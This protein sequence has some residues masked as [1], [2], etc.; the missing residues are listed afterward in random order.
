MARLTD[1]QAADLGSYQVV[2]SDSAGEVTSVVAT[3]AFLQPPQIVSTSPALGAIWITNN[4]PNTV[5]Q[6]PLT[7]AATDGDPVN[8][9]LSYQWSLDGTN[10]PGANSAVYP[11]SVYDYWPYDA[12]LEGDY[13]VT[14][15]NAAGSTNVG[16][17]NI[18]VLLQGMV[19]AWGDDA[20]GQCD[21][22]VT[23]TNAM[24]LAAGAY[25][26]AA[27]RDDGT[28][29]QW[30]DY[31]PDDFQSQN[32]PAPVGSPPTNS[33]IVAVAA[34]IAHDLALKA[35]GTVIQWGLAGASGLNN[36][37]TN[38]TGVKAVGV[39]CERS[40]ALLTN[41]TIVDWGLFVPILGLDQRVPADLTNVTA[42]SCGAYHYLA[43]R[44]NGTVASWG[45]N[46]L[47]GETNVPAGLSNVVAVAGGGRH[48]LAL[49]AD[50]TVVAWGDDTYGQCDVPMGL[51][52][53]MAIAA[54]YFHSVALKNDGTV[55]SWG[56]NSDGQTNTPSTL[57]QIKLIA[58]GG[59]HTL[60]SMFSPLVQYPMDVTKDLLLI[61]NSNSADSSN[62]CAHYLAHRPMVAD[63]NVLGVACDV[64]EFF[65]SSNNCDAQ[66]VAPVLNWLANNPTKHPEY[67]VLFYDIPTR[68]S[69]SYPYTAYG[70]VSYHLRQSYPGWPPFVNNINAGSAADCESYVDKLA[71]IGTNYSPGKLIISAS[72]GEYG[73]TNF[74]IDDIR[75]GG[76]SPQ[77]EDYSSFG[78][79]VAA[80]TN[81]LLSAGLSPS[82][83]LFYDG[84]VISNNLASAPPHATGITNI[85]GYV[86][87]GVH[88]AL[89]GGYPTN[90]T[91]VWNGNS[92]W[93]IIATIESFNGIRGGY[94]QG[95]FTEWY[96]TDAFGGTNYSNTPVGA[97][98]N[99]EEPGGVANYSLYFGLW[100]AGKN[101]GI[102][103]WNA[104]HSNYFQAIGDPLV[105]K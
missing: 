86:S 73:N 39:G 55:V 96:S 46:T 26:S 56:D 60:A 68:L 5:Y 13:A 62:V 54:G 45:Y 76:P 97:M 57:S 94:G 88:G 14:V 83:I 104:D 102:C 52:N 92:G 81:S 84:L 98:S 23:L 30:G 66:L 32:P 19:A 38:L 16:T 85:A 58:A 59:Y 41:G 65:A 49:K 15:S 53:V 50:G 87:W 79:T 18:R 82:A 43:L 6:F 21:R 10:I 64:G 48:S 99:T 42:I 74:V 90:R 69:N 25:H 31:A 77:Y 9:P 28:I 35:D 7:V 70:S 8:Y 22:P 47:F 12:P 91:V 40:L 51:S 71:H 2:I 72:A 78:A 95:N 11:L 101:L 29:A 27:V 44:A 37:P 3:L 24:A 34:G 80:V 61:Y 100:A 93:W 20:Y 33:D 67:I 63:A 75:N 36:F 105:T 1:V 89:A 4:A 17:W 103:A